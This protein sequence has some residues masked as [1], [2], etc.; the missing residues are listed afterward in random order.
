[1]EADGANAM[2][3]M[4]WWTTQKDCEAI[5]EKPEGLPDYV[6]AEYRSRLGRP[7]RGRLWVHP[8]LDW[9]GDAGWLFEQPIG[10]YLESAGG[11]VVAAEHVHHLATFPGVLTAAQL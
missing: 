2:T 7:A 1:M 9:K 11:I 5:G 4:I 8:S 10:A 3:H 6:Y